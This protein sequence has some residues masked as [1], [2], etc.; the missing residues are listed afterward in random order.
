MGD[1]EGPSNTL[2]IVG[3]KDMDHVKKI[4]LSAVVTNCCCAI[5]WNLNL[6]LDLLYG[7][8]NK[9]SFY[10][11]IACAVLWDICV[12]YL[13]VRYRKYKKQQDMKR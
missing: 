11:H 13:I 9:I 8:S 1:F 10:L 2:Q 6:F 3:G 4:S 7:Y 5:V 12:I